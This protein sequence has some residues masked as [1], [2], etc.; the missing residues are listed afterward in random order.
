MDQEANA[1]RWFCNTNEPFSAK[2]RRI[3]I[4]HWAGNAWEKLCQ[5]KYDRL[6]EKCWVNTGCLITADG[7]GD[8]HI[9]QEGLPN[10]VVPPPSFLDASEHPAI[11]SAVPEEIHDEESEAQDLVSDNENDDDRID[12]NGDVRNDE[13]DD[14]RNAINIFDQLILE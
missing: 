1:D 4:S 6:R 11:N 7:S 9:K 14:N 3:L 5:S 2:E 10:Y 13:V 8:E 12:E